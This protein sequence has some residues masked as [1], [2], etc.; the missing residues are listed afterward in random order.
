MDVES[1]GN[2]LNFYLDEMSSVV[3]INDGTLDKYIGDAIMS[4]WNAPIDQDDHAVLQ[5]RGGTGHET[6]RRDDP[7]RVWPSSARTGMLTRLGINSGPMAVGNMGST[8]KFNYTVLGDSREPRQPTRRRQQVLR[9]ADLDGGNHGQA[10]STVSLPCGRI[11]VLRVKGKQ[12]PMAVSNC[13]SEG[14]PNE[15]DRMRIQAV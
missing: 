3:S 14:A 9:H 1:L 15:T 11:D 2:M 8:R 13:L 7:P 6:P 12:Q 5:P 4:F 10:V